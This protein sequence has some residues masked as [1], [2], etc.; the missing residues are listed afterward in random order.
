MLKIASMLTVSS[1]LFDETSNNNKDKSMRNDFRA[2][3]NLFEKF[4]EL[5]DNDAKNRFCTS[6]GCSIKSLHLAKSTYNDL[7]HLLKTH[8]KKT[9]NESIYLHKRNAFACIENDL[10]LKFVFK[11]I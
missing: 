6:N 9:K 10:I 3:L 11:F 7:F 1:G 2:L 5:R 4:E 8:V